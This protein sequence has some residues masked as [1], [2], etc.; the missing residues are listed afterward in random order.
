MLKSGLCDYSDAYIVARG[1]ITVTNSNNDAY[2]KNIALK[3]N[4]P[5]FSCNSKI[6]NTLAD[7]AKDLDVVIL[8][9]NV[10]FTVETIEKQVVLC[11]IITDTNRI[12]VQ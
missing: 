5:F 11:G 7:N 6:D 2:D 9:Y 1:K 8:L 4:A 3:I 10:F 12:M